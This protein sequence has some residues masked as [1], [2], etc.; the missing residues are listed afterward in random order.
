MTKR[1]RIVISTIL[2][3]LGG[4]II[5]WFLIRGYFFDNFINPTQPI[6]LE[7]SAQF[8]DFIGGFVG[9]IFTIVYSITLRDTCFAT[10]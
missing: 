9:V 1:N 3:F 8:G 10:E 6:D 7:R 5:L 2:V 4:L